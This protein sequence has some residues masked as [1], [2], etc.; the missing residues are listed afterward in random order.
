MI[1]RGKRQERF[2]KAVY[3]SWSARS[4]RALDI[5]RSPEATSI[6]WKPSIDSCVIWNVPKANLFFR[7]ADSGYGCRT[8]SSNSC[9][10][11]TS[12]DQFRQ[13]HSRNEIERDSSSDESGPILHL[14]SGFE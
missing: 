10:T 11:E 1:L 5:E 13:L 14:G 9:R 6:Y 3:V 2:T 4:K 7:V 12:G 8:R